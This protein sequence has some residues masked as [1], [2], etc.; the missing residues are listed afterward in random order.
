MNNKEVKLLDALLTSSPIT[1]LTLSEQLGI[2]SRTVKRMV[3]TIDE[4]L[5]NNGASIISN[6]NGYEVEIINQEVF[7][8][9]WQEQKRLNDEMSLE[10]E[11][12]YLILKHLLLNK[13]CTQDELS[14]ITYVSRSTISK[15]IKNIKTVLEKEKIELGNRPHFGYFLIG[16]EANIRNFMVKLMMPEGDL[17]E[18]DEDLIRDCRDYSGFIKE[19]GE[20]LEK[21]GYQISDR[22]TISRMKYFIVTAVRIRN[23][24]YIDEIEKTEH[25]VDQNVSL[26]T[27]IRN[28]MEKYFAVQ[29]D[30][31]ELIYLLYVLGYT[32]SNDQNAEERDMSFYD[33][34]VSEFFT[35]IKEVFQQ[36]FFFDPILRQG[37]VQHLY[38]CYSQMLIN[39]VIDNPLLQVI[40]TQY[41]E[42]YNYAKLCGDVLREKY[43]IEATE[44]SLGYIAL[45]FAAAIERMNS[46]YKFNAVI[47]CESGFG[48]A[49]LLK[50]TITNRI[51]SIVIVKT[52]SSAELYQMDL[53]DIAMVIT[54]VK[55]NKK[56]DKPVI[57]INPLKL[58]NDI[59]KI[60]SYL[61]D[62]INIPQ[63]KGLFSQ[64]RFF[65]KLNYTNKEGLLRF[66]SDKLI[67]EDLIDAGNKEE[68][69]KREQISSTEINK[70]VAIPHCIVESNNETFMTV[71]TLKKP[72]SWGKEKVGIVFLACIAR[73]SSLNRKLFPLIYKLT[74]DSDKCSKLEEM[75]SYEEFIDYLFS[76]LPVEYG[77]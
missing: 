32:N 34:A 28:L 33:H 21:H 43:D 69:F 37:L 44:D 62:C 48:M 67:G 11:T 42:A 13:Y 40:K 46:L 23:K 50:M 61:K 73:K 45:H 19:A 5:R 63:Y 52:V 3:W 29:L 57:E 35:E 14:D 10:N 24:C 2:S 41:V 76:N 72:I 18:I 22:R 70:H 54:S 59:E 75:D 20:L 8:D 31:K 56:I 25:K 64:K 66:L 65:P 74:Y 15:Y 47:V 38:S 36:D 17:M 39:S 51:K 26:M 7:D 9:Y 68:I 55:L 53:S 1:S 12:E 6:K 49:E 4:E 77:E 60:D 30:E 58:E 27:E 16:E 71:A